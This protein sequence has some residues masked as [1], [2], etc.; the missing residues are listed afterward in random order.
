MLAHRS[1]TIAESEAL[2]LNPARV[3]CG[4]GIRQEFRLFPCGLLRVESL[5]GFRYGL[6]DNA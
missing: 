3:E 1:E 2:S 6:R 5:A 4:S